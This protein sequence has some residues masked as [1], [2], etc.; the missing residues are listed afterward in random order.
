MQKKIAQK[1]VIKKL[2]KYRGMKHDLQTTT[3]ATLR[4][5]ITINGEC[6]N[7]QSNIVDIG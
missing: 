1:R 6:S 4:Q 3:T 5:L 7:E 2:T